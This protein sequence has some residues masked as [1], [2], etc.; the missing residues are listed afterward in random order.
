MYSSPE[1]VDR[2]IRHAMEYE[3]LER[4]EASKEAGIR[5]GL[6]NEATLEAQENEA[7]LNM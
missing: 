2:I 4:K 5:E 7:M 3:E 1:M 6:E